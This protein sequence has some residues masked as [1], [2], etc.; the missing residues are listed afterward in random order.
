MLL[1]VFE[2][3]IR[4]TCLRSG[5]PAPSI[6]PGAAF[7]LLGAW[8]TCFHFMYYDVLLTA[9]AVFLLFT[10]P[11]RYLEPIYVGRHNSR[12]TGN[13][14]VLNRLAPTILALLIVTQ[15]LLAT[16]LGTLALGDT[17]LLLVLWAWCGWSWVRSKQLPNGNL[18]SD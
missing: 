5:R 14:C 2:A 7:V 15:P 1:F 4:L 8:A 13:V 9:L 3:T 10:E 11:R 6:G 18:V 16:R 17:V 12:E